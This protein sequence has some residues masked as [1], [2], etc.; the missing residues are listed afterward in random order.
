MIVDGQSRSIDFLHEAME[1]IDALRKLVNLAREAAFDLVIVRDYDRLARTRM[2]LTQLSGYLARCRVQIYA[3]DKPVEPQEPQQLGRGTGAFSSAAMVE[4]FSAI[5]AEN[6]V[7]RIVKRRHF[8][9]NQAMKQGKWVHSRTPY[10]YTRKQQVDHSEVMLDTP[11]VV[12]SEAQVIKHIENLYLDE[13]L[14]VNSVAERLNLESTPSPSGSYWRG[15]S[16][17][18]ILKNPFYCGYI[19]WGLQR[20]RRVFDKARGDFVNRSVDVPAYARLRERLQHTPTLDDLIAN[21]EALTTDDVVITRGDFRALRTLDRQRAIDAEMQLRTNRSRA[22]SVT[23]ERPLVFS[24][25]LVCKECGRTLGSAGQ[26]KRHKRLYYRCR[27]H[28]TAGDGECSNNAYVREAHLYQEVVN[29]FRALAANPERVDAY[30]ERHSEVRVEAWAE[31]K[32]LLEKALAG[33]ATRRERWA[34]AYEGGVI[35][36]ETYAK[37][38]D[39]VDKDYAMSQKRLAVVEKKLIAS[40]DVANR[41]KKILSAIENL[42]NLTEE[43]RTTIKIQ[44]RRVVERLIVD[45]NQLATIEFR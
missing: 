26:R 45:G 29:I 4:A 36:L 24:G 19:V 3:L 31:E 16:V 39:A 44:L 43:N 30:L 5:A 7:N 20:R 42:P 9:V 41:R 37:R 27:T 18:R 13:G 23:G 17:A 21:R 2:L 25:L 6:E 34:G 35:D 11:V 40:R 28:Y 38:L 33:I 10:G 15:T 32:L 1:E 22:T 14:G 8:G 12:E